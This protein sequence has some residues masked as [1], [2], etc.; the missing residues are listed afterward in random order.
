MVVEATGS[1]ALG[2]ATVVRVSDSH[3]IQL[4]EKMWLLRGPCDLSWRGL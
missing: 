2:K 4:M 3:R 1:P